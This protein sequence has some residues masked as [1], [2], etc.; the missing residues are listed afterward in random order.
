MTNK[1]DVIF[2]C[3]KCRENFRIDI[4]TYYKDFYSTR[5]NATSANIND[6]GTLT[7]IDEKN[8]GKP[9]KNSC[10]FIVNLGFTSEISTV[11]SSKNREKK[12]KIS[13]DLIQLF[14][15][16]ELE[17]IQL[18]TVKKFR[19]LQSG[20]TDTRIINASARPAGENTSTSGESTWSCKYFD[21]KI[22][23]EIVKSWYYSD[24]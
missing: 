23:L 16:C 4:T 12:I 3:Q 8:I 24:H 11:I 10:V 19:H 15:P 9:C 5:L 21:Y 17:G 18:R 2:L 22:F 13:F 20:I 7:W 1:Y 6:Y 14:K